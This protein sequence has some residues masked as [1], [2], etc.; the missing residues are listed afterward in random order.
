MDVH[1]GDIHSAIVGTSR[2]SGTKYSDSYIDREIELVQDLLLGIIVHKST[3]SDVCDTCAELDCLLSF[4]EASRA[5]DYRRPKMSS[6]NIIEIV[7][8]R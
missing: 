7:E 6:L 3:I 5:Y 8:G 1:I 2:C 4:A